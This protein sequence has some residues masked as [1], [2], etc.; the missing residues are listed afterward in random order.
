MI[1]VDPRF[2]FFWKGV[3]VG[4]SDGRNKALNLFEASNQ[5]SQLL[6]KMIHC[7]KALKTPHA[8]DTCWSKMCTQAKTFI[9][10]A[11]KN[12]LQMFY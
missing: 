3:G 4:Y 6:H 9:K 11:F 1:H 2:Y 7:F 8:G 12:P 10:T 5:L